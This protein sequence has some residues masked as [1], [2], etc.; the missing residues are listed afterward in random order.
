MSSVNRIAITLVAFAG[1]HA[2]VLIIRRFSE[3]FLTKRL[4]SSFS[5]I[6]SIVSLVTSIFVFVLYFAV[7]G[8]ILN[9]F[10][11][12]LTAYFVSATIVGLAVGFGSQGLVQDVVTGLTIVFSD[13]FDVGDMVEISGQSGIVKSIGMRF[14][15]LTNT[16]GAEVFIP[17]RTIA[18]VVNYPSGYIRCLADISLSKDTGLA[19]RMEEMIPSLIHSVYEQFPGIVLTEP[20]LEGKMKISSGKVF[21][22]IKFRLWPGRTGLIETTFK[23]EVLQALKEIDSS[24]A[25]WMVAVNYEV[26]EKSVSLPVWSKKKAR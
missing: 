18:N 10:G 25:E 6:K 8:F 19:K 4:S 9:E 3:R 20:S 13:I 12:S 17:N 5:K 11:V 14:T 21:L 2:T 22:R 1:A 24:Y 15:V 16:M 26:E 23:Q 7:L